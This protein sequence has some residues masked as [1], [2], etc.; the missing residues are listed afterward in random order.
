MKTCHGCHTT[1]DDSEFYKNRSKN[2]GLSSECRECSLHRV[3]AYQ[4]RIK[5]EIGA[6]E[7]RERNRIAVRRYRQRR[8]EPE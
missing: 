7:F 3:K 6:D 4:A 5:A 2:D 8:K 1:K